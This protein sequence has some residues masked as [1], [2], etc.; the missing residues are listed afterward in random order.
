MGGGG[1]AGDRS[2]SVHAATEVLE[3]QQAL[4]LLNLDGYIVTTA[5]ALHR[6]ADNYRPG[7]PQ[8]LQRYD[9]ALAVK[10][11]QPT[12]LAKAQALIEA[13]DRSAEAIDGPALAHDRVEGRAALVARAIDI[14]F[15]GI[16]AVARVE[17]Y[18]KTAGE[19]E[20]VI[21]R[22]FLLSTVLT[23]RRMLQSPRTHWTTENQLH[24]VL[25][26]TLAEDAQNPKDNCPAEPR[27]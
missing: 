11:N 21:V 6:P 25:D 13:A 7:D 19:P 2:A 1:A 10:A 24:W 18:R 4:A 22:Y 26:V 27:P 12:L 9:Y 23:R 5:D 8:H 16:A 14:D 3:A 17:G 15:P 20:P